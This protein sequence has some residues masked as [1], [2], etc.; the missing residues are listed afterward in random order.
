MPTKYP[1]K[2]G[3]KTPKQKYKVRNG[4]DYNDALRCRGRI[5]VWL[6]DDVINAWYEED[7]TY[8]GN[9][10]P[11]T[12]T[13]FAIITCHEIRQ[14]FRLPLRQCQ[15][16]I[17]SIFKA[18]NIDLKSPDY[19]CLSKRLAELNIQSPRYKKSDG[20]DETVKAIAIDSTGLKRFGRGE[21]HQEKHKVSAK[22]SWRKLHIAV[23]TKHIIHGSDLTDRF[24][25]DCQSVETLAKQVDDCVDHITADGAYDKNRVYDTLLAHFKDAEIIIPPDSDAV[26]DKKNHAQ[27]NSNLQAIKTFGRMAWQRVK[28]YG[29][30]NYSELAI[31]RY[32]KILGNCL[33]ARDLCRQKN[34]SMIGCGILNKMT[35][36]GMP[37]SYRCA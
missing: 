7:R 20:V 21:W 8:D 33:H 35:G 5:D 37:A 9:G 3:W 28:D 18:N 24:S 17:D 27:R 4:S 31:Q 25:S 16:F 12:F 26:Y 6:S 13:D 30:R 1:Y 2:K 22:R 19:S 34:E 29:R 15:G 10:A 14:V 23:D 32:K 11:K 36:L